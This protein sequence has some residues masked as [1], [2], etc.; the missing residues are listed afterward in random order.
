MN[1]DGGWISISEAAR[2]YG[3]SRKWVDNQIEEFGITTKKEGN[4]KLVQIA[5]LIAHRGEPQNSTDS[6]TATRNEKSQIV[7][8]SNS[9]PDALLT[10]EIQ[11]LRQRIADLEKINDRGNAERERLIGIIERQTLALPK[12]D[13]QQA[14]GQQQTEQ[15]GVVARFSQWVQNRL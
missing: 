12:P 5:D 15:Q 4:K 10:Q 14:T 3:K 2:L 9:E 1:T 6:N 8:P 7:T 13:E 11:F